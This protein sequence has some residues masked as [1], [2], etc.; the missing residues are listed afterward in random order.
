MIYAGIN[1][2]NMWEETMNLMDLENVI[3]VWNTGTVSETAFEYVKNRCEEKNIRIVDDDETYF[4]L[5]EP[6]A[7]NARN[8]CNNIK[9]KCYDQN[10][11]VI[12]LLDR[13]YY[14]VFFN[15]V[16]DA[17]LTSDK[18]PIISYSLDENMINLIGKDVVYNYNL[19]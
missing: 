6:T 12:N 14:T 2:A 4:Y 18:Y 19:V 7:E 9:S 10:C 3:I 15:A 11:Y 16:R 13:G 8:A 1:M 5:D 17:G